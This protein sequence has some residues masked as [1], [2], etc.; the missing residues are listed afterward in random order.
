[1]LRLPPLQHPF[2]LG[3]V[4]QRPRERGPELRFV[5]AV[6]EMR[7]LMGDDVLQ[8]GGGGLHQPPMHAHGET[9][10]R[11]SIVG[12]LRQAGQTA[13]GQ[14]D[15]LIVLACVLAELPKLANGDQGVIQ[16]GEPEVEGMG[17]P[18]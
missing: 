5:V 6:D 13:Q 17:D 10:T 2:P 18:A 12:L 1:M 16:Q 7:H 3:P 9:C 8:R 15:G 11:L 4:R 14:P